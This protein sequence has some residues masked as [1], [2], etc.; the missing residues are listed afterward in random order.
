[1]DDSEDGAGR[2]RR[3]TPTL[4]VNGRAARA[5]VAPIQEKLGPWQAQVVKLEAIVQRVR[6]SGRHDPSLAEAA[7]ALLGVVRMQIQLLDTALTDAIP[8]VRAHSRVTDAQRV[9]EL[10]VARL[11]TILGQLGE[12][13]N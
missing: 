4:V 1:M 12:A 9:L 7:R 10:L 6:A 8:A 3:A 2:N 5:L 11:E 13:G